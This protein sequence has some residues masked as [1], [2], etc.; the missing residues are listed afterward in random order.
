MLWAYKKQAQTRQ[1]RWSR[2]WGWLPELQKCPSFHTD[3]LKHKMVF[4]AQPS[5]PILAVHQHFNPDVCWP[6][7]C[8]HLV[9]KPLPVQEKN[10]KAKSETETLLCIALKLWSEKLISIHPQSV[11]QSTH[12]ELNVAG[13]PLLSD[14]NPAWKCRACSNSSYRTSCSTLGAVGIIL[15][16][17]WVHSHV[18]ISHFSF[19]SIWKEIGFWDRS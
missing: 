3:T 19:S 9:T 5:I 11:S 8:G 14:P 7:S 16:Y 12:A 13:F 17:I 6:Y 1:E 15:G 18:I 10:N 4:R 2:P